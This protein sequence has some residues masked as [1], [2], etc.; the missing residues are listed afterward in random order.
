MKPRDALDLLEADWALD[1]ES[2]RLVQA[3]RAHEED[4]QQLKRKQEQLEEEED[5]E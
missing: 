3:L 4:V 5:Y 1:P 2:N